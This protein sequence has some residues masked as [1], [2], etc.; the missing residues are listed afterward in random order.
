M[1]GT[2]VG[3]APRVVRTV[4]RI[5]Q[6]TEFRRPPWG[7]G[8]SSNWNFLSRPLLRPSSGLWCLASGITSRTK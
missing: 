8:W 5:G 1:V 2:R 3:T 6:D 7:R 4:P